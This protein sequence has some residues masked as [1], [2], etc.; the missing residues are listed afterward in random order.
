MKFFFTNSDAHVSQ[1]QHSKHIPQENSILRVPKM[2]FTLWVVKFQQLNLII[3]QGWGI[4]RKPK[5]P[6]FTMVILG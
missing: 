6:F 5:C 1:K 3:W 2:K 4:F